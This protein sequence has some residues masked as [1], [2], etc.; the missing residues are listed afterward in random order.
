M[1]RPHE[2]LIAD[3]AA[4]DE[5]T[6]LGM[7][8]CPSP[9][10]ADPVVQEQ[11]AHLVV[12][13]SVVVGFDADL[14]RVTGP[15]F[16]RGGRAVRAGACP[17]RRP[18]LLTPP[19]VPAAVCHP[20][21][22]SAPVPASFAQNAEGPRPRCRRPL[23]WRPAG[24]S[25]CTWRPSLLG[26][27]VHIAAAFVAAGCGV[28]CAATLRPWPRGS[29]GGGLLDVSFRYGSIGSPFIGGLRGADQRGSRCRGL[30]WR[31]CGRAPARP[32]PRCPSR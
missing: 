25:I 22:Q 6:R 23:T 1:Y 10:V 30:R 19:T 5:V 29:L 3:C 18:A 13:P 27:Q 12:L 26:H 7:R 11:A 14:R 17:S 9:S 20:R 28:H 32:L 21:P 2:E 4:V 15:D 24:R 8:Y 16:V 31:R